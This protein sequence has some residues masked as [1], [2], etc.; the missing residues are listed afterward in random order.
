MLLSCSSFSSA[1]WFLRFWDDRIQRKVVYES[2]AYVS[3]VDPITGKRKGGSVS[4]ASITLREYRQW[5]GI[6]ILM[7]IRK[8]PSIRNYWRRIRGLH[9]EDIVQTMSRFRFLYILQ[10]LYLTAKGSFVTDKEDPVYDAISKC[11]P[12]LDMCVANFKALW[13]PGEYVSIDKCMICYN[14]K[15]YS[16]K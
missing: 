10:C 13:N 14:G 11:H 15:Y 3:Y 4:V 6:V 5:C 8:Q 1:D 12:I 16:F 2:N 9:Y 7:G